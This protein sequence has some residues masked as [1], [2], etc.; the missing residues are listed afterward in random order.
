MRPWTWFDSLAIGLLLLI[1]IILALLG[2]GVY[3]AQIY[4]TPIK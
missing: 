1:G 4:M 2:Y 3:T